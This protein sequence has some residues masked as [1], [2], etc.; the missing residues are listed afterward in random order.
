MFFKSTVVCTPD[1][2]RVAD[3]KHPQNYAVVPHIKI[4]PKG[5][6][7]KMENLTIRTEEQRLHARFKSKLRDRFGE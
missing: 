4:K 7:L 1:W 3:I 2:R 5:I 6:C